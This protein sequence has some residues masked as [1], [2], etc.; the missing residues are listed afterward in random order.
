MDCQ[1]ANLV[2]VISLPLSFIIHI[3]IFIGGLYVAIHSRII[4]EWLST[5][6]WYVGLGS[7]FVSITIGLEYII[8]PSFPMSYTNLGQI[9]ELLDSTII[10]FT[11]SLMF[12]NTLY[13]DLKNKKNRS[14]KDRPTKIW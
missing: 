6:L 4:P 5:C 14:N 1:L 13:H 8:G 3:I 2:S 11:V 9:A 7:L 10:A 12:G